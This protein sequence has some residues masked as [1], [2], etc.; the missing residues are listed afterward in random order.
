[1]NTIRQSGVMLLF[2]MATCATAQA[3][4]D[5]APGTDAV[6]AGRMS[7]SLHIPDVM[8]V[9]K[10]N[11]LYLDNRDKK[12]VK[13]SREL[14]LSRNTAGTLALMAHSI[15]GGED[16]LFRN[17]DH[18]AIAY[19]VA[20]NDGHNE[21]ALAAGQITNITRS[22]PGTNTECGSGRSARLTIAT[23]NNTA[24]KTAKSGFYSDLLVL[25]IQSQ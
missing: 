9:T 22:A 12:A 10:V 25:T 1:M 14:C 18:H 2:A 13:A 15:N 8:R 6:S 17:A 5:G 11:D 23:R 21:H 19:D 16:F 24:D 7:V 20:L 3:A 4:M